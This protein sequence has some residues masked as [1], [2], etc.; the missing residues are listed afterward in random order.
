MRKSIEY[1]G[2]GSYVVKEKS[3]D[4]GVPKWKAP[5]VPSKNRSQSDRGFKIPEPGTY[6]PLPTSYDLFDSMASSNKKSQR[7]RF[8]R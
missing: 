1:P 5:T 2:V 6:N 7:A 4:K 8:G 3:S